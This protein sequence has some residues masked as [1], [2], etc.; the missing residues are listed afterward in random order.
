[1]YKTYV[2]PLKKKTC[3][4]SIMGLPPALSRVVA[5]VQKQMTPTEAPLSA[6]PHS[7]PVSA[8]RGGASAAPARSRRVA[9][10][11]GPRGGRGGLL[12]Q[13]TSPGMSRVSGAQLSAGARC[14]CSLHVWDTL[15]HRAQTGTSTSLRVAAFPAISYGL[16]C[17]SMAIPRYDDCF[18][19]CWSLQPQGLPAAS[20]SPTGKGVSARDRDVPP[21]APPLPGSLHGRRKHKQKLLWEQRLSAPVLKVSRIDRMD[22]C[23]SYRKLWI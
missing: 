18:V 1:M 6:R 4:V 16:C 9:G 7:P 23:I 22:L 2:L 10:G 11:G 13:D 14:G 12:G 15:W 5:N 19:Q 21:P 17:E 20:P 8:Q 3:R